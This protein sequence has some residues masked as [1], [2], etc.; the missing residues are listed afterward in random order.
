[1][2]NIVATPCCQSHL[3]IKRQMYKQPAKTVFLSE[4]QA[5][6]SRSKEGREVFSGELSLTPSFIH[7]S[8]G[9]SPAPA[10][11]AKLNS[12]SGPNRLGWGT[13]MGFYLAHPSSA[14]CYSLFSTG[15]F[16]TSQTTPPP[17][18]L[19]SCLSPRRRRHYQ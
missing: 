13:Y 14:P 12:P 19:I 9:E 5:G 1:M 2:G 6:E 3:E 11:R 15:F 16:T 7:P 8:P 18:R 4:N 10:V 17:H